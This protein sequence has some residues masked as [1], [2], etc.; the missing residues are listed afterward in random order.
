MRATSDS[1][2]GADE[3]RSVA[4]PD[5]AKNDSSRS[6]LRCSSPDSTVPSFTQ[7]LRIIC[8]SRSTTSGGGANVRHK[9]GL[10]VSDDVVRI[11]TFTAQ[12]GTFVVPIAMRRDTA[13]IRCRAA[14]HGR[15]VVG[16]DDP[17]VARRCFELDA[18]GPGASTPLIM[19]A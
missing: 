19:N 14:D 12:P 5:P 17:C 8:C 6:T 7:R 10:H 13:P 1:R 15:R 4:S 9:I 11:R 16:P 3:C 2:P 18:H